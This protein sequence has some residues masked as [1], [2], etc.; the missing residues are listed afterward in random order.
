MKRFGWIFALVVVWVALDAWLVRWWWVERREKRVEPLLLAAAREY[1]VEPALVKAV[2]WRESRFREDARGT[3]GELGLM[4]IGPLAAEEWARAEKLRGFRHADLLD[5]GRNA[6]AGAWYL[7]KLLRRYP[8]TDRPEA[9]ALADYNAGRVNVLR[10]L[11][12]EAATNSQRF[13]EQID[14]PST[15]EYILDV[16]A[17]RDRYRPVFPRPGE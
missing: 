17:Q 7:A 13:L 1:R 5:P 2:A 10:W 8:Q 9:F 15:R 12:G 16:L 11:K 14:Y 4:Q 3:V 6:R